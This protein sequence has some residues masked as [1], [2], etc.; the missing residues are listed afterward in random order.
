MKYLILVFVITS[1][2]QGHFFCAEGASEL[3]G[4]IYKVCGVGYGL[5]EAAA[6][7]ESLIQAYKEFDGLCDR[8]KECFGHEIL[9]TPK[10]VVCTKPGVVVCQRLVEIEVL[11]TVTR[12]YLASNN[13][14]QSKLECAARNPIV[15]V[16]GLVVRGILPLGKN[17]CYPW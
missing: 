9:V 7:Q 16:A 10:R 17:P 5:E 8:D 12:T 14:P 15:Y 6:R 1:P 4:S 13:L 3:S 2:A 11:D